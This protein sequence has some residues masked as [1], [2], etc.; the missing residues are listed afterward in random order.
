M[1]VSNKRCID[2]T[3]LARMQPRSQVID[4]VNR[5]APPPSLPSKFSSGTWQFSKNTSAIGDVRTPIFSSL[6]ATFI[7]GE[8]FST[9]KALIPSGP[10]VLSAVA[11]TGQVFFLLRLGAVIDDRNNRRPHVGV[12]REEQAVV[13]AGVPESLEGCH[14]S[15]WILAEPA[16]LGGDE[17]A[18]NA[19]VPAFF[20]GLVV[21]NALAIVLDHVIVKLLA[22]KTADR[23]Q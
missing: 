10:R 19:E 6:R 16:V 5:K 1:H 9:R 23:V 15:E 3:A 21:E 2:P 18:L 20:P 14:G 8:S 4:R 13:L 11:K 12:D 22:S 17:Q 7:P